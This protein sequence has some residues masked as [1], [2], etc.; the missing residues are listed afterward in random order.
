MHA[1]S[2]FFYYETQVYNPL[3]S[4][5]EKTEQEHQ[6]TMYCLVLETGGIRLFQAK[7]IDR[8]RQKY[9]SVPS[10]LLFILSTT[11]N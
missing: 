7:V 1:F 8:Q 2:L 6:C 3:A 4:F 10:S 9:R 11:E 5:R